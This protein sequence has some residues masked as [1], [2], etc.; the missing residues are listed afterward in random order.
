ML[1]LISHEA[2]VQIDFSVQKYSIGDIVVFYHNQQ[3]LI[4]RIIAKSAHGTF[5][6]KGDNNT[7]T[8]GIF[9]SRNILGKVIS[10]NNSGRIIN[11]SDT[12]YKELKYLL[13]LYSWTKLIAAKLFS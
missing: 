11:I 4:H 2:Y 3:L 1:P 12:P 9:Q 5:L 6:I 10:V 8:D 13:I 7:T